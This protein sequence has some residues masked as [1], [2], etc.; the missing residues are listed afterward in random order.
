MVSQPDKVPSDT[1]KKAGGR[2]L[3]DQIDISDARFS[4][5]NRGGLKGK[6]RIDFNNINLSGINGIIEDFKT[7]NDTVSFKIYNLG[8]K[9]SCGFTVKKMSSTVMIARQNIFLSSAS[10][11]CDSSIFNISRFGLIAD[12]AS[13]FKKFAEKVKLD[14]ILE[15]SLI[16]TSDLQYFIPFLTV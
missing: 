2:Y 7:L 13:S 15:K 8:F 3:I 14:I 4:L 6:T 16:N 11:T 5:I 12:S 9:E 10:I 1:V